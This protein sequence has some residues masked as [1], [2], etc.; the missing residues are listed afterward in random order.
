LSTLDLQTNS[1]F[2]QC[3]RQGNYRKTSE[4][5]VAETS[6]SRGERSL[7]RVL[8]SRVYGDYTPKEAASAKCSS[9]EPFC[10]VQAFQNGESRDL[11]GTPPTSGLYGK[12]RSERCIS[13]CANSFKA[14]ET[15]EK[16]E[17]SGSSMV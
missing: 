9:V 12:D 10:Q 15:A 4:G 2:V 17:T 8:P 1:L 16:K 5:V 13:T 7:P 3:G 14:S 11:K 6:Y